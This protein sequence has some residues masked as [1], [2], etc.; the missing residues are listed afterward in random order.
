LKKS[1][2]SDWAAEIKSLRAKRGL[3][4]DELAS[5]IGVASST[6]G[7]W[8]TG[9]VVPHKRTKKRIYAI[10][11]SEVFTAS[12]P[13]L[14]VSRRPRVESS[15]RYSQETIAELHQALDMILDNAPSA[16]VERITETLNKDAGRFGE[17]S[18][19]A[20]ASKSARIFV[21]NPELAEKIHEM[22]LLRGRDADAIMRTALELGLAEYKSVALETPAVE[23]PAR[24]KQRG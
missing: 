9:K 13:A 11:Q 8:E 19:S 3:T 2:P 16:V 18:P 4:Q 17:P 10:F 14:E 21:I 6:I 24:K 15:R 20:S 5:L 22:V 23:V 12:G 1:S 7:F